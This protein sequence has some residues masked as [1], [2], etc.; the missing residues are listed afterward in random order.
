MSL[1]RDDIAV[2]RGPAILLIVAVCFGSLFFSDVAEAG[3]LRHDIRRFNRHP[4]AHLAWQIS[5]R[6]LKQ[7]RLDAMMNW[8]ERAAVSPG[9]D[10][11]L[12]RTLNQFRI[13]QRWN[14]YDAGIASIKLRVSP[15]TATVVVDDDVLYPRR[16]SYRIWLSTGT[17]QLTLT[18][19]GHEVVDRIVTPRLGHNLVAILDEEVQIKRYALHRGTP[20]LC[21]AHP[22]YPPLPLEGTDCQLWGVVRAVIHEY[23][24]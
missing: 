11:P 21:S 14:V 5:Q 12:A 16:A 7:G 24:P 10:K 6:Y 2:R 4:A 23:L 1:Y 8:L 20:H 19:S 17:H 22:H 9:L 3:S 13:D 15:A 18:A